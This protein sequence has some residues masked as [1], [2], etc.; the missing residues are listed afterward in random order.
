M[1]LAVAVLPGDGIGP[2]VTAAGL[3]VLHAVAKRGGHTL[4][5]TEHPI[6]WGAVQVCSDPLPAETAAA[7]ME[8]RAVLLGAV[9]HPDADGVAPPLR[10]ESG[11]L[12][13][14]KEL[15]CF[16]NLRPARISES[17][18]DVSPLRPDVVRGTD[19]IVVREL[20]GG[21][22]YGRASEA[23][24]SG[25]SSNTME[26]TADEV[27]RVAKI[28]F[29]LARVRRGEVVS[30][31]KANV[32]AVSR[33]WRSVVDETA[34]AYSGVKCRHMLVDR[35]AM[36]LVFHPTSF[37]VILTG[38]LFGDILSDQAASLT[39]SLGLLGSASIGGRTDLYEPVH[40]SA[41][42]IAG[43]NVANPI[44]M[45]ASIAMM[46]RNTFDLPDEATMVETGIETVLAQGFRTPD[47]V[48]GESNQVGTRQ[49]GEL[50]AAACTEKNISAAAAAR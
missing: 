26:Y 36:E 5:L 31:D 21:I 19:L 20:A 41:P 16:A 25:R 48:Y 33:L 10:P 49:F 15:G 18:V 45:I 46:L 6:G 50:V 42:D 7:C 44:G 22:Y 11:L 14:R 2:E 4:E 3:D 39:G 27:R 23:A 37:D 1:N 17:L 29:Q 34:R 32:L 30:V 38:N 35:A 24:G 40:G 13:L 12:R 28:A 47:L 9:G 43:R 8:K